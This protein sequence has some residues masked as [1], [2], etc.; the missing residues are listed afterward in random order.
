LAGR[1]G[2]EARLDSA[3]FRRLAGNYA[4]GVTIVTT[5]DDGGNPVGLTVNSFTSVSLDPILV[6]VSVD[7]T[8]NSHDHLLRSGRFAVTILSAGQQELANR[9]AASDRPEE[10]WRGLQWVPGPGGTPIVPGGL[11]WMECSVLQS[12]TAGDHTVFIGVVEAGEA[13]AGNEEPLLYFRGGY[14]GLCP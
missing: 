13:V 7:H 2:E 9:F 14:A 1:Q 4:T 11:A 10:R 12:V 6:S 8:A 3:T 5:L